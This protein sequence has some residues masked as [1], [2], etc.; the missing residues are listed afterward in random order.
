MQNLDA[1]SFATFLITHFTSVKKY[2]VPC[3]GWLYN[4][5]SQRIFIIPM[6]LGRKTLKLLYSSTNCV[7]WIA[8]GYKMLQTLPD[9]IILTTSNYHVGVLCCCPN[10]DFSQIP[11]VYAVERRNS[12]HQRSAGLPTG[13]RWCSSTRLGRSWMQLDK[14]ESLTKAMLA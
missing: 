2:Q 7:G 8:K 14:L 12:T 5:D 3:N 13:N 4:E 11:C 10:R 1:L 6:I 9:L